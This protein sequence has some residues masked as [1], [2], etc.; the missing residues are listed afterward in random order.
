M[1]GGGSPR[2]A[3]SADSSV[4]DPGDL[5]PDAYA[6]AEAIKQITPLLAD[7]AE[8]YCD[9]RRRFVGRA[10]GR[11]VLSFH[12]D[13][14]LE[15]RGAAPP[16]AEEAAQAFR[17]QLA[18]IAQLLQQFATERAAA[19]KATQETIDQLQSE[20]HFLSEELSRYRQRELEELR[21][22]DSDASADEGLSSDPS[23]RCPQRTPIKS[24]WS[25]KRARPRSS[26][27]D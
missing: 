19:L 7:H 14:V 4:S 2:A 15:H 11:R 1:H 6:L 22:Q 21:E 17:R 13:V 8:L 12:S 9:L 16:P 5:D 10:L 25:Q 18:V 26:G 20:N 23:D 27:S 24:P 3:D